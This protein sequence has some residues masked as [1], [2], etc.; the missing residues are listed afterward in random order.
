MTTKTSLASLFIIHLKQLQG[1]EKEA[2]QILQEFAPAESS[3]CEMVLWLWAISEQVGRFGKKSLLKTYEAT[4][5]RGITRV[6]AEW[7]NP[8]SSLWEEE[9]LGIHTS[10]VSLSYAALMGLK[11]QGSLAEL[12]PL[13]TTIRDSIFEHHLT[14]GML[15][16]SREIKDV[17]I[18]QLFAVMPF[19]LF[20]PEDLVMVEAV[21][22]MEERLV[23]DEGV[24]PY[25]GAHKPSASSAMLLSWYFYEKGTV[26]K[27]RHYYKVAQRTDD[28]NDS[29]YNVLE[30]IVSEYITEQLQE[31]EAI[32]V[33]QPYGHDNPYKQIA[34]ERAPRDPEV[35]E[36]VTVR[37]QLFGI[38]HNEVS[39][40]LLFSDNGSETTSVPCTVIKEEDDIIWQ[41][42]L[43][44]NVSTVTYWF[45][46]TTE[47]SCV[48]SEPYVL[49]YF[50]RVALKRFEKVAEDANFL[51]LYGATDTRGAYV[52]FGK[53]GE[54]GITH[55]DPNLSFQ[56]LTGETHYEIGNTQ[57]H[58]Q[59]A[60]FSINSGTEVLLSSYP[61]AT[62]PLVEW[63]ENAAGY[64]Q[65]VEWNFHTP[66]E[67][68]FFGM[69]ER[70]HKLEYR[71]DEIDCYVY[72]QYRDQGSRTY[73]PVPFFISS[74]GYGLYLSTDHYSV[75]D[76][77][78]HYSNRLKI[79]CDVQSQVLHSSFN[80]FTGTPKEIVSQF[81]IHTGKAQLPPVWAF[82][83][84]MSSNNW[85][86]DAVVREQVRQTN[87]HE[88]PSTVLV[89][90]QWSDEATYYI[91][92]DAEYDL[93]PG[94]E[95]HNYEDYRYPASGRWPDPKGLFN[96]LHNNGLKVI[97]WQIPIQKYLNRQKHPQKDLDEKYMIE[98]GYC[99]KDGQ[100]AP[101][102]IREDW[103]KESLLMD[104]THPEGKKWWFQKRKYLMDIGVDGF[105][106]DGGE[107]VFG[108]DLQFHDGSSGSEMRNRY[109]N[110]YIEAYY[111]FATKHH[112]GDALTF[113][114]A[115]YTGAQKFPAH[116]AGD[117][118]STFDAFRHS[119]IAGLSSGTSGIPIWGWDLAGFNGDIPTAELF[120][121]SAQ[122]AAFSP[123]MQY[124]AESKAEFNQDR[125]PWNIANR[126]GDQRAI[127]GYR[128]FANLRMNLLPYIYDQAKEAIEKGYPLMRSMVMEYPSDEKV[129]DNYDQ[130]FFGNSL[131]VAPVIEEGSVERDV[132]FPEGTW[133]DFF[134]G[135]VI[136]GPMV[137]RVQASLM[138]M[139][140]YAKAG[141]AVV[142]NSDGNYA[143]CSW[144]GNEVDHYKNVALRL[145]PIEKMKISVGDH[146]GNEWLVEV[147]DLKDRELEITVKSGVASTVL[148]PEKLVESRS[149]RVNGKQAHSRM[150]GSLVFHIS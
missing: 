132:Y 121:R 85:D 4:I 95:A 149:V 136:T 58:V 31:G 68:R 55:E 67:E 72:N 99:V 40:L 37:S 23:T 78:H 38:D 48:K 137:K 57:V 80:L 12:Q 140:V 28:Q 66:L 142:T 124:H 71:G 128:K 34:V 53:S 7:N 1:K 20:S 106:T 138:E 56:E 24:F 63:L 26:H 133:V 25:R 96:D 91:F 50:R 103:F 42:A 148:I 98:E 29:F 89:I 62:F 44:S 126:T 101:Y 113:S 92:N 116:W 109:P 145:Y 13:L 10:V 79:S 70:Y 59:Q 17:A 110:D 18:E 130:Y 75:F 129:Y 115:G 134:T 60:S 107:F 117:E 9:R 139:P 105:K 104:F 93:K 21:K 83:P 30:A 74:R 33:H 64:I 73:L 45:E 120:I 35:G 146:L 27:A 123:I 36:T 122:M 119:L 77:A 94:R 147:E 90:E 143:L 16:R 6:E 8:H 52:F 46:A 19:G 61:E 47:N 84:W 2:E 111:D 11:N 125:T 141:S 131:M 54:F 3:Y 14:G 69:G 112:N 86:R 81:T 127:S 88:I 76:F 49:N 82:G 65:R 39:E 41:G 135:E 32:I 51:W 5:K 87:K 43:T 97:L 22:E 108:R 144:V 118:R 150:N 114:R 15:L 100:G 102:R